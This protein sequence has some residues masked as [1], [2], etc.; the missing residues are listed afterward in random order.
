MLTEKGTIK[1]EAIFSDDRKQRYLLRKEWDS[2][3]PKATIIMSNPSTADLHTLD[4][5]TLY[6]LN[7]LIKLNFGGVDIVNMISK[8]TRKLDVKLDLQDEP[9]DENI[10][11]ILKSAERA[12]KVIIAWGK[13]GVSGKKI[14]TLQRKILEPLKPFAHKLCIIANENGESG[15]HPLAPQIRFSWYLVPFERLEPAQHETPTEK[16]DEQTKKT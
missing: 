10:R 13:G 6:I 11:Q 1:T 16:H 3:K 12:D 9:T 14:Q 8:C 4:Y 15:F 7:N 2:K 5:T